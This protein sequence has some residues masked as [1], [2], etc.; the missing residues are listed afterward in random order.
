MNKP[1]STFMQP[2]RTVNLA[3]VLPLFAPNPQ[4][5]LLTARRKQTATLLVRQGASQSLSLTPSARSAPRLEK[6]NA[7]P[8]S[9]EKV[10]GTISQL[11]GTSSLTPVGRAEMDL[12]PG[13]PRFINAATLKKM[14]RA[15]RSDLLMKRVGDKW[16][17]LENSGR[18]DLHDDSVEF[19]L[20]A[21]QVFS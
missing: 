14:L 2:V 3:R 7:Q 1:P 10:T 4:T 21:I 12:P 6:L 16:E 11:A 18:I 9:V 20:G 8:M 15:K 19:R 13:L 5:V 17:V